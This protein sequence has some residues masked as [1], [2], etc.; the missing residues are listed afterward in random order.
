MN[1]KFYLFAFFGPLS[2]MLCLFTIIIYVLVTRIA[3]EGKTIETLLSV[4]FGSTIPLLIFYFLIKRFKD[5][6]SGKVK[7]LAK[8]SPVSKFFFYMGVSLM[9]ISTLAIFVFY[10]YMFLSADRSVITGVLLG[11]TVQFFVIGFI[12]NEV[13]RLKPE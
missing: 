7:I 8:V 4:G 3:V 13:S 12:C 10:A 2:L 5:V 1:K 11:F 6:L 9:L